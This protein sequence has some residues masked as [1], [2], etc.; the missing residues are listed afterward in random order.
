MIR[1]FD[2]PNHEPAQCR[3]KNALVTDTIAGIAYLYDC[4][5]SYQILNTSS[6]SID[7]SEPLDLTNLGTC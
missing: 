3:Y 5:G 2:E 6:E 4:A 1:I 7:C